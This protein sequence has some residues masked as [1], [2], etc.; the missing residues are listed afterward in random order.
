LFVGVQECA[1]FISHVALDELYPTQKLL[2][3]LSAYGMKETLQSKKITEK[4]LRKKNYG[5][6]NFCSLPILWCCERVDDV[7]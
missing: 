2:A 4:K 3:V 5:K 7:T 1:I 6:K